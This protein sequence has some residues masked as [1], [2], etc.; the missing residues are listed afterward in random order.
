MENF[1]SDFYLWIS[2]LGKLS[3]EKSD[4]Y[5]FYIKSHPNLGNKYEKY[6]KYTEKFLF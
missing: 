4:K 2:F 1:F 6:Q 5:D 3:N